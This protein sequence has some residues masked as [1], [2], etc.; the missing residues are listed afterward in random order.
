MR[1]VTC[2]VVGAYKSNNVGER[3]GVT[4]DDYARNRGSLSLC[5]DTERAKAQAIAAGLVADDKPEPPAPPEVKAAD[6]EQPSSSSTKKRTTNRRKK[7]T[8][9]R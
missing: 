2:I 1:Q 9:V 8:N 7:P 6:D 4:V 3:V 5:V